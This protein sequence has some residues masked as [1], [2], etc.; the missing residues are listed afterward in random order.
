MTYRLAS[1]TSGFNG[2]R[3]TQDAALAP[4]SEPRADRMFT[5]KGKVAALE[6]SDGSSDRLPGFQDRRLGDAIGA[7]A[8][9]RHDQRIA[10]QHFCCYI[11]DRVVVGTFPNV[12]FKDGDAVKAVVT[13]L[14]GDGVFAHAVMTTA[15]GKLWLPHSVCKGTHAALVDLAKKAALVAA[16]SWVCALL[17]MLAWPPESGVLAAASIAGLGI[18]A[19]CALGVFFINRASPDG[20]YADKILTMLG[21]R[22]PKIVNLTPFSERARGLNSFDHAGSLHVYELWPALARYGA[23]KRKKA[24]PPLSQP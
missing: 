13:N 20:P 23:V 1:Q 21:F 7:P 15:N 10:L 8:T 6:I 18:L 22:N 14:D 24:K 11:G 12:G 4:R 17:V 3:R 5:L 9:P 2:E 19:F 16:A